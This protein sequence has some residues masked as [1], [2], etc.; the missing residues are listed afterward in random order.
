MEAVIN[1]YTLLNSHKYECKEAEKVHSLKTKIKDSHVELLKNYLK[2]DRAITCTQA[3]ERLFKEAGLRI[4]SRNIGRYLTKLKKEI[5]LESPSANSSSSLFEKRKKNEQYTKVKSYHIYLLKKYLENDKLITPIRARYQLHKDT[6]LEV[7]V[8]C[9]KGYILALRDEIDRECDNFYHSSTELPI[10]NSYCER[11][12]LKFFHIE[13]LKKY[14]K[15]DNFITSAEA[16]DKIHKDTGIELSVGYTGSILSVLKKVIDSECAYLES[17]YSE[18][19]TMVYCR[20]NT[21]LKFYHIDILKG[22]LKE[23]ISITAKQVRNQLRQDTRLEIGLG[24]IEIHLAVLRKEMFGKHT[25]QGPNFRKVK[26]S[27]NFQNR[28]DITNTDYMLLG[29]DI[30]ISIETDY[31]PIADINNVKA[32]SVAQ[33]RADKVTS[34]VSMEKNNLEYPQSESNFS[35]SHSGTY[36]SCSY[37]LKD[38]HIWFLKQYLIEDNLIFP[39]KARDQLYADTGLDARTQTIKSHL[40]RLRNE[41]KLNPIF[42]RDSTPDSDIILLN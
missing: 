36:S 10:R 19:P 41:M 24:N 6:G 22:Y 7:S 5:I 42:Y 40:S 12:K 29:E 33:M 35:Y 15:E 31:L 11:N 30:N 28:A 39:E 13:L 18:S 3:S 9:I 32:S 25:S 1:K 2:E 4:S 23:N 37:K 14:L 34:K 20:S 38:I 21:K 27:N 17:S 8:R 26:S 16:R